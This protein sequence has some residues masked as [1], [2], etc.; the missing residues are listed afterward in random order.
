MKFKTVLESVGN[1]PLVLLTPSPSRGKVLAKLEYLNP[2]GSVK[3][4]TALY[5]IETA[6]REG[7]LKPGGTII[8]ASSGNQGIALALI[9]AV[10]GYHV[11]IT[12]PGK[13]SPEKIAT[14]RAYGAEV[15][16]C[17]TVATLDDPEGYHVK[18]EHLLATNPDAYMPDQYHNKNNGQAHYAST[19]PEIWEQTDGTVTHLFVGMG[20][21][22]TIS[23]I[24]RYIKQKNPAVQVIGVDAAGSTLSSKV[25]FAYTIEGIGV[26]AV[27]E[28]YENAPIDKIIAVNDAD[29]AA[30]TRTLGKKYGVL[31]G[32]SSGAVMCAVEQYKNEL[33]PDS[34]SVAVFG[35]SGRAYLNKVFAE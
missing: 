2:G 12:V 14:L 3:D 24:A 6:E 18:A 26:D 8:E 17:P 29:A 10:K 28:N 15:I 31:G 23:G 35:D 4:R 1:T 33:G 9:G 34:I 20:T 25:P 13:T 21:C 5:M 30:M 22:G 16:V 19:G 32:M 11:I 7:K 27:N